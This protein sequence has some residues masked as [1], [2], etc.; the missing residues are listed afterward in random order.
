MTKSGT[1]TVEHA[2]IYMNA[3]NMFFGHAR[4]GTAISQPLA[5]GLNDSWSN[6]WQHID[7]F[8]QQGKFM[9]QQPV[10]RPATTTHQKDKDI[11]QQHIFHSR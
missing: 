3:E 2:K 7:P 6:T 10:L 5:C 4:T 8:S 9:A 11:E 1:G